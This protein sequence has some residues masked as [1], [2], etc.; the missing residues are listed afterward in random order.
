MH[1]PTGEGWNPYS[2]FIL[3]LSTPLR[4][5]QNH[6]RGLGPIQSCKPAPKGAVLHEKT[7]DEG[8]DP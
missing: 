6:R 2:L 3:V 8:W 1:K 7:T 4:I 5:A